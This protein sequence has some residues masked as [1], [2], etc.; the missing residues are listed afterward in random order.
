MRPVLL[1]CL[2]PAVLAVSLAAQSVGT[3]SDLMVKVIYPS[4]DAVF[5]IT[6][7]TPTTEVEWGELQA[8]AL[9][10]AESANLLAMPGYAR[11]QDRWL[12]DAKLMRE[13][14]AAAFRAAKNKDLA[15]LD[16]LNEPLYQSC[17]TC[18]MHYRPNYR[19]RPGTTTSQK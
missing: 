16:A 6:S 12:A 10:L 17:T 18:H 3:V 1:A 13:A 8:K 19:R 7:R 14:G 5:Y 2:A 11:D 9:M 4:S 15:A